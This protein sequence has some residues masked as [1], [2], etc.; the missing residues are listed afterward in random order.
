MLLKKKAGISTLVSEGLPQNMPPLSDHALAELK[1]MWFRLEKDREEL[2]ARGLEAPEILELLKEIGV[3]VVGTVGL[4]DETRGLADLAVGVCQI[5]G[6]IN[7]STNVPDRRIGYQ[8]LAP[9]A[10]DFTMDKV[11]GQSYE[12]QKQTC[13]E[14][15]LVITHLTELLWL[16]F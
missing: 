10:R 2:A 3:K 1:E 8:S 4:T 13:H 7:M 15:S 6:M 14:C 5:I 16:D 9:A 12:W 11:L